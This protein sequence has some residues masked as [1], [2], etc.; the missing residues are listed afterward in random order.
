MFQAE[1]EFTYT[2]V[3]CSPDGLEKVLSPSH[4]HLP[5]AD[6]DAVSGSSFRGDQLPAAAWSPVLQ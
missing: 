3:V 5:Q 2:N 1:E 6:P 4:S